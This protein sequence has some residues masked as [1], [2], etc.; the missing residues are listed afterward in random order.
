ML[1]WRHVRPS[2]LLVTTN[3][4]FASR[5]GYNRREST[6]FFPVYTTEEG[7]ELDSETSPRNSGDRLVSLAER[8]LQRGEIVD[9]QGDERARLQPSELASRQIEML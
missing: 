3:A 8:R 9:V 7:T 1:V 2:M 5:C 6:M 4:D